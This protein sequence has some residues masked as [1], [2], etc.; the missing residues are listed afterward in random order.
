MCA[1]SCLYF[2]CLLNPGYRKIEGQQK[3]LD[4]HSHCKGTSHL[5]PLNTALP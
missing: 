1:F 3:Q 5:F 4:D 2:Q